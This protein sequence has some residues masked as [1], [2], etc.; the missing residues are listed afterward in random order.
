[1][2]FQ[3][4]AFVVLAAIV[5]AHAFQVAK[6]NN[7][8]TKNTRLY[9]DFKI[10]GKPQ[11]VSAKELFTEKQLREF[12]ATYSVDE[13]QS[14]FDLVGSLFSGSGN[15]VSSSIPSGSSIA[16]SL[17]S[18]VSLPVLEEKTAAYIQGKSDSRSFYKVLQAAFGKSLPNVLPEIL[19][20][21]PAKKASEL[22]KIA[23]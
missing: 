18:T 1:M 4:L 7:L 21:L 14:I 16:S 3:T 11:I 23:K 6:T 15:K 12:T 20:S 19:A 9:E 5:A 10:G 22:S 17:K 13:R 8:I 2:S